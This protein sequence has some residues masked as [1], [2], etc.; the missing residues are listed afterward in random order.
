MATQLSIFNAA[1]TH[2]GEPIVAEFGDGPKPPNV[3]KALA[4]WDMALEA[5]LCR[6][7]WLCALESRSLPADPAPLNGDWR[8]SAAFTCP[9][10]TLK[11]WAVQNGHCFAW[12]AA[13]AV[14]AENAVRQVIRANAEGPLNVDLI[15]RRRAEALSPLLADALALELASRLAGPIKSDLALGRKLKGDAMD[16]YAAAM[17]SEASQIGG[18]EPTIPFGLT[19]AR[20]QAQ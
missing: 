13:T 14:D 11:V 9:G 7:P 19:A 5:A 16:A 12:Q 4:M 2:L 17:G 18:Q 8:Y 1:F 15:M 6:A 3:V 10:G 20:A